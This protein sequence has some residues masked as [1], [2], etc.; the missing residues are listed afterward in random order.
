[1]GPGGVLMG[2]H[3][4]GIGPDRPVPAFDRVAASPQHVQDLRLGAVI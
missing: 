1:M 3:H 2:M 4:G